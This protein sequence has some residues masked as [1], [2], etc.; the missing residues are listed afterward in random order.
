MFWGLAQ[1]DSGV[2]YIKEEYPLD[3]VLCITPSA[4]RS[5][6]DSDSFSDCFDSQS[7]MDD[8]DL[9]SFTEMDES[10]DED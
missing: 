9:G 7:S 4:C 5:P 8:D 6:S 10:S 2:V 3:N 1:R